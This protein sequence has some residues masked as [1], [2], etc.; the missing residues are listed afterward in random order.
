MDNMELHRLIVVV[1]SRLTSSPERKARE[2]FIRR[3]IAHAKT[4]QD[5][6]ANRDKREAAAA[7]QIWT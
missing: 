3:D 2:V 7:L 1:T 5:V 4:A 6:G